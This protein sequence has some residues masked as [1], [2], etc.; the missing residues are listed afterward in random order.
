MSKIVNQDVESIVAALRKE[1]GA[2]E[3]K[4]LLISG[5]SGFLGS[6][7]LAVMAKLN[8]TVFKKP[9]KV[10][11]L[12]NYI[13]GTRQNPLG[14]ITDPHFT[15]LKG[16]ICTPLKVKGPIDY[17]IHMAGIAS[18]VY[19]I[20]YPLETI[21]TATIGTENLLKLAREKKSKKFLFFSSSEI[22]GDPAPEFV[23]TPE[24][25]RGNVS[26]V[27]PRACYDESKRLGETLCMVYHSLYKVPVVIVRPFNVYG[28]GMKPHDRRV[29]PQFLS[30]AFAGKVLPIHG[31]GLQTRSYCYTTDA[32]VGFFKTI[33]TKRSGEVYN[34]GSHEG[35]TNL[36]D[37]A[38]AMEKILGRKLKIA[39][40]P[41][42]AEYPADEPSRRCPDL[43]KARTEL[44]YV[45]KVDLET[46]LK[47]MI[48]WYKGQYV[49]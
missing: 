29:I 36:V 21:H 11:T 43:T 30:C 17:I 39:K 23:P 13:T 42:P 12:D 3:G 32:L 2:L 14:D 25:Y 9:C 47:R 8:Q 41:Y 28:P 46:G 49:R 18:P 15:Y 33:L 35:E 16:D 34:I 44:N 4:T 19:Y 24:T 37:L 26:S 6:H 31:S 48:D 38:S 22:Y 45:P 20:K 10:I 40:I 27:G 7:F 1:A 5:G